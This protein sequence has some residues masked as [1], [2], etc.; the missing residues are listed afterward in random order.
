MGLLSL[1]QPDAGCHIAVPAPHVSGNG[2]RPQVAIVH[3]NDK[4]GFKTRDFES[5]STPQC[6]NMA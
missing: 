6:Q 1:K 2:G 3:C 5:V 4:S